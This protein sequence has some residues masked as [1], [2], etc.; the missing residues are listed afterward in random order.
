[1]L[2]PGGYAIITSPDAPA[3]ERDTFRCAHCGRVV[4]VR[5]GC[6]AADAGGWC[7]LEGKPVCGPCADLGSCTPLE[8]QLKRME[9][10]ARFRRQLA[11]AA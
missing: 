1:M 7:G 10:R 4:F 5:P 11:E 2:R 3:V 6:S 9:D 8:E